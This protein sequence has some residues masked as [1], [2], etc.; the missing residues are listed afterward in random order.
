M[1]DYLV[2]GAG[3]GMGS[4][5]C[6]LLSEEGHRVFGLDRAFPQED[7]PFTRIRA[8][9]TVRSEVEAAFRTVSERTDKLD[10]IIHAA[11]IYDLNSLAEMPEEDFL[12]DFD[13]NL[14]AA[15]RVNRVFLPLLRKGRIVMITSELAP[16]DPLP[17]TGVYAVTKTA[18]DRYASALRMEV[19]LLGHQVSV[20]RPGAVKTGLL[21]VS[22]DKLQRF[23]EHTAL[24]PVNAARFKRIVDRVEAKNVPPEAVAA[25]IRRALTARR[26]KLVYTV[27]RNPLLLLLQ[28]LPARLRLWII[29]KI[30]E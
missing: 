21:D 4:A 27:N 13:V 16:L 9:L 5:V 12:R 15:F 18:L 7:G 3:G 24:Y 17:F 30:L 22:T 2:T 29:R 26:P 28:A 8:D 1:A 6:R 10:G 23:C 20:I 14:F 25:V 19:Q 11:G